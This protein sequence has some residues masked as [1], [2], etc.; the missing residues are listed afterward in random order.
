MENNQIVVDIEDLG[1][2]YLQEGTVFGNLVQDI[3][4]S[5][6]QLKSTS[7]QLEKSLQQDHNSIK[8]LI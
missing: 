2:A 3:E 4:A 1:A 8:E 7:S 5:V 6:E